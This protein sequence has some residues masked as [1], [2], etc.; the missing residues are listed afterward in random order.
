MKSQF[1]RIKNRASSVSTR[2]LAVMLCFVMLLTAVGAG[3]MMTAI[4]AGGSASPV[5]D[6]AQKVI[7]IA[8]SVDVPA[9]KA[10]EDEASADTV[11][12]KLKKQS[13]EIASTGSENETPAPKKKRLIWHRPVTLQLFSTYKTGAVPL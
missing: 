2:A 8:D 11:F 6:A 3:T 4:A 10:A 5:T 7:D 9:A 12:D 13:G 1:A